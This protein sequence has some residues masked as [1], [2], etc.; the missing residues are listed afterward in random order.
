MNPDYLYGAVLLLDARD[1]DDRFE[2][3]CRDFKELAMN[4]VV[5][6]PPVFY[7]EGKPEAEVQRR[8]LRVAARHG[9]GVIVELTGQV[10][11]LEYLPDAAYRDE[12]AVINPD[13]TPARMQNGLGERNYNHPEVKRFLCDFFTFTVNA[14]KDEP[15][16]IGWDIWN[17]SHFKS[18]DPWT[19]ACFRTWLEKRYT[20]IGE[21]NYAWQKSY[22]SFGEIILDPVTW[23]SIS[24]DTD[25]EEFRTDNLA[26]IAAEWAAI[27]RALDPARPVI[28][29]NVMSNAVWSEFD[30]GSDDWKLAAAVDAFGISFY[31]KTG[32]RLL[33]ENAP[34]LRRLT[35]A[36]A[37]AAGGGRFMV[38]E[39]QSHCYSE[40]FTT[41]RVSPAELTDWNFEALFQGCAGNI[42][43]KWEPFKRGFQLGGRGLVLADG[44]F[45]K[46][47]GAAKAVGEFLQKH[48]DCARLAPMHTAAVLYDRTANFTVKAVNTRIRHL[49]GDDQPAKARLAVAGAAFERNV[50]L[51]VVTAED[52]LSARFRGRALFLPYQVTLDAALTRALE[53]LLDRGVAV[54]AAAPCG[55]ISPEGTLYE[56]LPGGLL[57]SRLGARM[58]DQIEDRYQGKPVE[59]QELELQPG[60]EILL[61]TDGG[62][63]LF[64]RRGNLFYLACGI[65][66]AL[67]EIFDAVTGEFGLVPV[68]ASVPVEPAAGKEADYLWIPNYDEAAE[69]RVETDADAELIFGTGSLRR[70]GKELILSGARHVILRFAKRCPELFPLA[71]NRVWRT[72]LGGRTLDSIEGKAAPADSHFPEDWL[73]S[74]TRA[75]NAG[76]TAV[77]GPSKVWLNGVLSPL[78]EWIDAFPE[79]IFGAEH[80]Q[81]YGASAGFLLKYLDSSIRLHMQCHPTVEFAKKHLNSPN[82]KTEGYIILGHRPEVEPYIYLGF[83]RRPDPERFRRAILEQ[84]TATILSFFDRIPVKAGDVFLV[85]GGVPHAIGEGVFMIEMMEPTDFAVRIEF[86]RGGYTLPESARFMGRDVDFA[87][88]MFDYTARTVEETRRDFFVTPRPLGNHREQLF[89]GCFR[90][91]RVKVKG[92]LPL[93][94]DGCRIVVVTSG[95]GRL[96][97]GGRTVQLRQYDRVLIPHIQPEMLLESAGG[98]EA[99]IAMPPR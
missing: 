12:F 24:P 16:L 48:P 11:N 6:W 14:L 32:G 67:P 89:D 78:G 83:Q 46:R 82:G 59:I 99:V 52:L 37:A 8:F 45:S 87:L 13:G 10:A 17:E 57:N 47:A 76:R 91:E 5:V 27:V 34:P 23:A 60:A 92:A 9:L 65:E 88:S 28:A 41:E 73:F 20:T 95:S 38:S 68:R 66:T 56:S 86:E 36:G 2:A 7:R 50:P 19:I 4:T 79:A 84:D 62:R 42:Y 81:K 15:A 55:D 44:T 93:R 58:I 18:F 64:F 98:L 97:A 51:G 40:I 21:L 22:A 26:D 70:E 63:P 94:H 75:V 30:R 31:P 72:Y 1:T 61:K 69:I 71:P 85:P 35:F 80:R 29:D 53:G 90:A 96:T 39:M 74:T 54:I 3:V 33:R 77:E 49:L 25:W 43:W